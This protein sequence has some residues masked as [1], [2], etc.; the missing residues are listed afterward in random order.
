MRELNLNEAHADDTGLCLLTG[1]TALSSLELGFCHNITDAGLKALDAPLSRHSLLH[2][3]VIGCRE[4]TLMSSVGLKKT[5]L[6]KWVDLSWRMGSAI[7]PCSR[8][9]QR[10]V[11]QCRNILPT[12]SQG[13]GEPMHVP[14][15][16]DNMGA[17]H[18]HVVGVYSFTL[19]AP[20]AWG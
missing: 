4:L 7:W 19:H 11:S 8:G 18:C 6:A 5:L 16:A 10:P 14:V 1:L 2:V 12:L 3:D 13:T 20:P 17:V 15:Q 9:S